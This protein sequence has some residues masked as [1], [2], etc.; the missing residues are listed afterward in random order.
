MCKSVQIQ[1]ASVANQ[2]T[3]SH[4]ATD[5]EILPYSSI[6]SPPKYPI[7]GHIPLLAKNLKTLHKLHTSLQKEYGDIV[8][9]CIPG[10]AGK[11]DQVWC[12]NPEDGRTIFDNDGRMPESPFIESLVYYRKVM[13][14]DLFPHPGVLSQNEEWMKFRSLVNPDLMRV[15][16]MVF[17][18]NDIESITNDLMDV[19]EREKDEENRI[20]IKTPGGFL[21]RWALESVGFIFLGSRL[22]TLSENVAEDSDGMVMIKNV[23]IM[24]N[25][26]FKVVAMPPIWKYINVPFYKRF[27]ESIEK[28][29]IISHKHIDAALSNNTNDQTIIAKLAN[30]CGNDKSILNVMALDA[31]NAGIH[32]TSSAGAFLL[33]HLASNQGKQDLL[34]EEIS[35]ALG[36]SGSLTESSL[37]KMKYLRNCVQESQ[38]LLPGAIGSSR[39]SQT[40]M[41]LGGY[42]IPKGTFL[43]KASQISSRDERYFTNPDLFLPERW[44]RGATR[45]ENFHPFA[46]LPF[47]HGPRM[48]VGKRLAVMELYVLAVKVLQR[49]RLEY[50][51]GEVD[52][53]TGIVSKPDGDVV[54]TLVNRN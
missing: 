22:G 33:Y 14:K 11:A 45:E 53:E 1:R 38:R 51:G 2:V 20:V 6:P 25:E 13:R 7:L 48:C 3:S 5:S 28:I 47:G 17:Y 29:S 21:Q 50:S 52:M 37:N 46:S 54:I 30:K 39:L 31:F 18:L 40:D 8:K 32:T 15:K 36:V 23:D 16:S 34:F 42:H 44:E 49:Y 41:V 19:F 24:F 26:M 35:S 4:E 27:N 10:M 12:Y 43:T 9:L